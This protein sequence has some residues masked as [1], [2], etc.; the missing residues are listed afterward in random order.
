SLTMNI[1]TY[2]TPITMDT[3]RYLIGVYKNTKTYENLYRNTKNNY[4]LLQI[5]SLD[6]LPVVKT[7]GKKS[8]VTYNKE[9]YLTKHG[10]LEEQ[11]CVW[12]N[13]KYHYLKHVHSVLFMNIE[14]RIDIGDH[15]V[16]L[17]K[18]EKV[19]L[20]NFSSTELT[21]KDLQNRQIVG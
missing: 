17:A 12:K 21:T 8:A 14:K 5:L 2:V 3:K 1:A 20:T 4:F 9:K 19:V 10:L 7:L 15:D 13:K 18:V 6:N 16:L 11:T